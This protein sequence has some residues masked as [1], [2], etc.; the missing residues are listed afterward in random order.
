MNNTF[1]IPII[2]VN[3]KLRVKKL[4]EYQILDTDSE[5]SFKHVASLA[6]HIFKVPI[7][8][9]SFV[10]T[11]R[12]WFK[13]NVGMEGISQVDRG[14]SLCSL[15]ILN[16]DLTIFP[17]ALEE[18]CLL[19]NP[20]VAGSFGL[21][22]YAAAPLRTPDGYNLGSVCIVDKEPREFNVADQDMLAHLGE[23]VMKELEFWKEKK[24]VRKAS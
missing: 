9:V 21:R 7:A 16:D 22:F 5:G 15:S 2:P 11:D 3:D 24:Q 13:A 20:L 23:L 4:Q 10:D 6:A 1:G 12:V 17:D 14:V 8:L 18:P 19:A